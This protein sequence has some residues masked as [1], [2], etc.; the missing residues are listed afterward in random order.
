MTN[1]QLSSFSVV[2]TENISSQVK[3]KTRITTLA[4]FIQ[5]RFGNSSHGNQRIKRKKKG[6]KF[7]KKK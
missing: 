4:T 1:A 3:D 7:E 6:S 5:H 2:K